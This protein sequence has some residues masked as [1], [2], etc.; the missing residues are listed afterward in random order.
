[1][2][3]DSGA[4]RPDD[5]FVIRPLGKGEPSNALSLEQAQLITGSYGKGHVHVNISDCTNRN[6]HSEENVSPGVTEC[7][8]G[9]G[10]RPVLPPSA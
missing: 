6:T 4:G 5:L 1:M 9:E 7:S 3:R 2:K 10:S 8:R